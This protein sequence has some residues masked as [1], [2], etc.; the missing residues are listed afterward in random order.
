MIEFRIVE[1]DRELEAIRR[2][3]YDVYVREMGRYHSTADHERRLLGDEE[4]ARSW[5][6]YA[7]DGGRV[8]ASTRMTW[9]GAGIS[10]RQIEQYQ[11][12]QFLAEIPAGRL[13]VGERTMISPAWRGIDLFAALTER[14]EVLSRNHD[15]RVVFGACEPHLLSFY[16]NYQRPYGTRNINSSE[17]GLLVPLVAFPEG[18]DALRDYG[19]GTLPRCINDV[20]TNSGTVSG[21][22]FSSEAEYRTEVRAQLETLPSSVF[23][24]LDDTELASCLARSNIITC[25][26]GDRLL[27]TGGA[28]R[29]V[30][31]VLEGNLVVSR[32]E[33][34]VGVVLPGEVG[35]EIAYLSGTARH[36]DVDVVDP[37]TRVLSLSERTLQRLPDDHPSAAARFFANMARQLSARLEFAG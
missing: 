22:L 35:G 15:V 4:D 30:F 20:V 21:P 13:A 7:T 8:V 31:V 18:A 10:E 19:G 24:G 33:Q 27:K 23:D 32:D 34:A 6:V 16:G 9:G 28:A 5:T 1:S 3:R 37:N 2:F 17:A 36:F 11:L 29:N 25:Q 26:P 14:L 12:E